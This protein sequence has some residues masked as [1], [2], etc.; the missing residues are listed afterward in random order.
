MLELQGK[1][2]ELCG[3]P[4]QPP[5]IPLICSYPYYIYPIHPLLIQTPWLLT[6]FARTL[7]MDTTLQLW[8]QYILVS[9]VP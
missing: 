1:G 8:D 4:P 6:V 5:R 7:D 2:K 9:A 3:E